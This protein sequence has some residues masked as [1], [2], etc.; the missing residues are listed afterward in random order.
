VTR[1][2][3]LP[4]L[5]TT[6]VDPT[7]WL[8]SVRG[9]TMP[10]P[11]LLK[12]WD[13]TT[14]LHFECQLDIDVERVLDECGLGPGSTLT[15]VAVWWASSTNK[16][17]A[18]AMKELERSG[19]VLLA[20]DVDPGEI[21]GSITLRRHLLL[22]AAAGSASA[23]SA[24]QPGSLLW[25]EDR[26]DTTTMILEGD[27]ARFP[28]EV[29]DFAERPVLEPSAAWWLDCRFDDLDAS[30]LACLR[31]FVNGA[32][33]QVKPVLAGKSDPRSMLVGSVM[34]WDVSRRMING[35]LDSADF[36]DGW[37][38]FRPGSL[39]EV[40]ELLIRKVWPTHDAV[41]LRS[42]RANDAGLFEARLQG[43]LHT[44]GASS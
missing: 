28:T 26:R 44:L 6:A 36:V 12:A 35:A 11:E 18:G 16:R 23:F 9:E 14:P 37:G 3:A 25:E 2:V 19:P 27:A 39:G 4:H 30:P 29:L 13:Y 1:L 8:V 40:L 33:P 22:G 10:V 31:L 42:L 43:R 41:A 7:P 17:L 20:F 21:G 5:Q 38:S 32:H 15:A 24:T 34:S